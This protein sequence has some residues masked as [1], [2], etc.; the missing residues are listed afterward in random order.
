MKPCKCCGKSVKPPKRNPSRKVTYCSRQCHANWQSEQIVRDWKSGKF[1]G[2]RGK[3]LQLSQPVRNYILKQNGHKCTQCG[4]NKKHPISGKVPVQ[5]HHK[6][7]NAINTKESNLEVLCPNCHALTPN[8]GAGNLGSG[9]T[10]K[11]RQM[12][13][14]SGKKQ[15]KKEYGKR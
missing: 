9:R 15:T 4:W 3:Q 6:D 2:V 14:T 11:E 1:N 7:G 10:I 13:L 8:W 5:V 12:R